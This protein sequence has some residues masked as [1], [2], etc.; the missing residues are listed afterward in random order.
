MEG[1][2]SGWVHGGTDGQGERGGGAGGGRQGEREESGRRL[3]SPT[4]LCHCPL[5]P[6]RG[7]VASWVCSGNPPQHLQTV[8]PPSG[9]W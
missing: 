2:E 5:W 8:H 3:H 9:L 6:L 4:E 1:M 7:G